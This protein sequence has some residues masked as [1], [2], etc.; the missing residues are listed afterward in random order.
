MNDR[1]SAQLRQ[2]LLGVANERPTDGQLAVLKAELAV[3]AQRHPLVARLAWLPGRIGPFPSAVVRLGLITALVA[4]VVGAA[5]LVGSGASTFF[6]GPRDGVVPPT[7]APTPTPVPT[8]ESTAQLP[9]AAPS[10]DAS[11]MQLDHETMYRGALRAVTGERGRPGHGELTVGGRSGRVRAEQRAVQWRWNGSVP[12]PPR[13]ATCTGRSSATGKSSSVE[14][15]TAFDAVAQLKVQRGHDTSALIDTTIGPFR[16]TRLDFSVPAFRCRRVRRRVVPCL[17]GGGAERRR[18]RSRPGHDRPRSTSPRSMA[19]RSW[20]RV[21]YRPRTRRRQPRP[22]R[23][24][25]LASLRV[26]MVDPSSS[27]GAPSARREAG[28]IGPAS[29]HHGPGLVPGWALRQV[30]V[31]VRHLEGLQGVAALRSLNWS[32]KFATMW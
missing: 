32:P 5:L 17:G 11:C 16:A 6:A 24:A 15:P 9:T 10:P 19:P 27:G 25:V 28:P 3:T 31:R 30:V 8:A 23:R 20:S 14:A 26:E 7:Q 29:L 4:A 2:H 22:D 12:C 13:E 21:G 18:E 1:F